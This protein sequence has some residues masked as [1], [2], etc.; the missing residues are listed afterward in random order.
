MADF[1]YAHDTDP[2]ISVSFRVP[3]AELDLWDRGTDPAYRTV[4]MVELYSRGEV[5]L[6]DPFA[7]LEAIGRRVVV[8]SAVVGLPVPADPHVGIVYEVYDGEDLVFSTGNDDEQDPGFP[9][10]LNAVTFAEQYL[11][12]EVLGEPYGPTP[13]GRESH[14]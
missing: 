4:G 8:S 3:E 6:A 1:P 10:W 5:P 11:A 2:R 9:G 12:S 14:T 7:V 13:D